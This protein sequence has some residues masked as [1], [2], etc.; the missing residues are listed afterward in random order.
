[1]FLFY[2][3]W[4]CRSKPPLGERELESYATSNAAVS[5]TGGFLRAIIPNSIRVIARLSQMRSV[6]RFSR[7]WPGV[8]LGEISELSRKPVLQLVATSG[9]PG[10]LSLSLSPL[11]VPFALV[12]GVA[13]S[14]CNAGRCNRRLA[15]GNI[16]TFMTAEWSD[17]HM[18]VAWPRHMETM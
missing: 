3:S 12:L 10:R 1:M 15:E 4:S 5:K 11:S 2:D 13:A 7:R 16:T 9:V 17:T 8:R 6:S 14:R 18:H